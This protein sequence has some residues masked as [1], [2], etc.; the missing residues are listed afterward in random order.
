MGPQFMDQRSG[1]KAPALARVVQHPGSDTQRA[2]FVSAYT[3]SALAPHLARFLSPLSPLHSP[4]PAHLPAMF[5]ETSIL[6]LCKPTHVAARH[7]D[8]RKV[9]NA[10]E[11]V[12]YPINTVIEF[13]G[14][15]LVVLKSNAR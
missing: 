9:R 14:Q 5:A 13:Q 12:S 6:T 7:R 3:N 2:A 11:P 15:R 10:Q 1:L 4:I 8:C